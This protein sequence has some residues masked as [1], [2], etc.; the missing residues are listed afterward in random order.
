MFNSQKL[1]IFSQLFA[2][3][4]VQFS[5]AAPKRRPQDVDLTLSLAQATPPVSDEQSR[6]I[7]FLVQ[8]LDA[9]VLAY[10]D[11][12]DYNVDNYVHWWKGISDNVKAKIA[13]KFHSDAK[14]KQTVGSSN[15]VG[16]EKE[17]DQL[18][19][20]TVR[21]FIKDGIIPPQECWF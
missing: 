5:K 17:L 14:N 9:A 19:F 11:L 6:Q 15:N 2:A 13:S 16:R 18:A 4:W 7:M 8:H 12:L 21:S 20:E 3:V 1:I 10:T